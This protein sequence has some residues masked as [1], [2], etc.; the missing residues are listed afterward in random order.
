[1]NFLLFTAF[2]RG[3]ETWTTC[4]IWISPKICWKK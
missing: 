3:L 1:L 4:E 2:C